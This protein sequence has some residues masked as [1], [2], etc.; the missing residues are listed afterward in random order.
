[1]LQKQLLQFGKFGLGICILIL[2]FILDTP[3]LDSVS[4]FADFGREKAPRSQL[5]QTRM[6][7]VVLDAVDRNFI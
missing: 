1:M 7:E 4:E 3:D 5:Y 6:R 2:G